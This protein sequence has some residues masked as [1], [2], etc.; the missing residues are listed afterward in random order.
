MNADACPEVMNFSCAHS[1]GQ[2][3]DHGSSPGPGFLVAKRTFKVMSRIVVMAAAC[4]QSGLVTWVGDEI[5][6][7]EPNMV[8]DEFAE[9]AAR[10]A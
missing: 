5:L 9:H 3:T 6:G 10:A 2:R 4:E 7:S 8:T 1:F